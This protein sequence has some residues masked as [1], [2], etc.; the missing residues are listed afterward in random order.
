MANE[1]TNEQ[2][3]FLK[4]YADD[5]INFHTWNEKTLEQAQNENKPI[6]IYVG[7]AT[8][9]VCDIMKKEVLEDKEI[10]KIL[11]KDFICIIID[12][13]QYLE[14]DALYQKAHY[15]IN[16]R[17]GGW[18]T[19]IFATPEN[20]VF[21]V[22]TFIQKESEEGSVEGMG[23]LE[24]I[25]LISHKTKHKD[26]KLQQNAKEVEQ[27]LKNISHPKNATVL[28]EDIYKNFLKF[29]KFEKIFLMKKKNFLMS[30][31]K[32]L[33]LKKNC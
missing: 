13:F 31:K 18:P 30:K 17:I 22:G 12:K 24:L 14:L 16:S 27:F 32:I 7:Y 10:I 33:R 6:F 29:Q 25:K 19:S 20:Q 8:C 3:A 2:S 21:F 4:K 5:A 15:L 11:N 28:K 1:L 23:F 26:I 9:N